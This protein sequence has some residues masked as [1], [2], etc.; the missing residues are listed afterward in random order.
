MMNKTGRFLFLCAVMILI[1]CAGVYSFG[2]K[3]MEESKTLPVR[4]ALSISTGSSDITVL[5]AQVNEIS[6][7][8]VYT[9]STRIYKPEFLVYDDR[10]ELKEEFDGPGGRGKAN[11]SVTVPY[12]IDISSNSGSGDVVIRGIRRDVAVNTGSGSVKVED[13]EARVE[14]NAGSGR[15]H[16]ENIEGDLSLNT[17]SGKI[18]LDRING[19][20]QCNTGSGG[21]NITDTRGLFSIN[22]GSGDIS[23]SEAMITGTSS[24]NAGSGDIMVA[25]ADSTDYDLE[26]TT[27]SGKAVLSYGGNSIKGTFEFTAREDRGKIVSPFSFDDETTFTQG[28]KTYM[29]KSFTRDNS[30]K[31]TINTGTGT[32]ELRR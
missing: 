22:S 21:A 27:G 13:C 19:S 3:E 5:A 17:G 1:A 2:G 12:N 24:L 10:I 30:P 15:L 23:I 25:L 7:T 14:V 31:I 32:A 11:W 6:V 16:L 4:E 26:L 18:T 29:R 9:Y 8:V 28:G 20:I